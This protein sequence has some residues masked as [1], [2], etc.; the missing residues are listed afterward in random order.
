MNKPEVDEAIL[1]ADKHLAGQSIERRKA[2]ALDIQQAIM[3]I[4]GDVA[5]DAIREAFKKA[6]TH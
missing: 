4:A 1:I 5:R 6:K 2:L 3:R